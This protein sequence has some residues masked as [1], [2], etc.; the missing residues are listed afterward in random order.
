MTVD[1]KGESSKGTRTYPSS[2]VAHP[3][4]SD[5]ST[6]GMSLMAWET[7]ERIVAGQA[8]PARSLV[9]LRWGIRRWQVDRRGRGATPPSS[10]KLPDERD[11]IHYTSLSLSLVSLFLFLRRHRQH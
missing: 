7:S 9:Q 6:Q 4:P 1:M 5:Q 10:L 11:R 3:Q 8:R 2:R